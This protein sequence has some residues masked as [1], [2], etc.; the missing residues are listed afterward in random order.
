MVL[1]RKNEA[2]I[3]IRTDAGGPYIIFSFQLTPTF[4]TRPI[5]EP[6]E[7]L[8]HSPGS[9]SR[10]GG[11]GGGCLRLY[12]CFGLSPFCCFW[13]PEHSIYISVFSN[14]LTKKILIYIVCRMGRLAKM[15]IQNMG[16]ILHFIGFLM[17]V[18]CLRYCAFKAIHTIITNRLDTRIQ[19]MRWF[20]ALMSGTMPF[21]GAHCYY[22]GFYRAAITALKGQFNPS[23]KFI[24]LKA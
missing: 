7:G 4:K 14:Q 19:S 5:N 2:A 16:V 22:T 11:G 10:G 8:Y 15:Y 24:L 17:L 3:R 21:H 13:R 1:W 20:I 6:Q 9:D 23:N 12:D 18:S